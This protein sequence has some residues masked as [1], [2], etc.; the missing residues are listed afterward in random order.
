[1]GFPYR[2]NSVVFLDPW[3]FFVLLTLNFNMGWGASK[4]RLA[5]RKVCQT[6]SVDA[7]PRETWGMRGEEMRRDKGSIKE[8]LHKGQKRRTMHRK[9]LKVQQKRRTMHRKL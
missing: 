1:M 3:L 4:N 2:G 6:P 9:T 8:N 5:N 7:P